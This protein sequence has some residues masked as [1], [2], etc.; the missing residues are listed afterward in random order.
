MVPIIEIDVTP[1]QLMAGKGRVAAPAMIGGPVGETPALAAAGPDYV[2]LA[3]DM[4]DPEEVRDL[5]RQANAP[6]T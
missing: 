6:A 3:A 2:A 4:T 1:A 5:W